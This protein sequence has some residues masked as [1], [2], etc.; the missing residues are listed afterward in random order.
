M[1]LRLSSPDGHQGAENGDRRRLDAPVHLGSMAGEEETSE[2]PS[3][4]LAHKEVV[5]VGWGGWS[6]GQMKRGWAELN[7]LQGYGLKM[8]EVWV[9]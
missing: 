6:E 3:I 1:E 8:T 4:W 5:S 2:M 9:Q 7:G